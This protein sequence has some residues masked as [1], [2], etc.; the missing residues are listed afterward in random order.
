MCI[1][2]VGEK[3]IGRSK[4]NLKVVFGS[5]AGDNDIV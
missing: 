2:P 1:F 4:K 3:L 5:N